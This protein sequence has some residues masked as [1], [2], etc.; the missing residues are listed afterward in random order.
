MRL[1]GLWQNPDFMRLWVGQ[2]VSVFGSMIGNLAL[3]FVAII[4]LNATPFQVATLG[5]MNLIPGFMAGLFAGVWVDRLP[6]K[7]VLIASDIGRFAVLLSVPAAALLGV[8]SL[9]QLYIVA[10]LNGVF[11]TFFDVAYHA[12]LPSLVRK[13]ELIEGNSK[14]SASASVAEAGG[15][16][17]AG[18][19]VQWLTAP[20]AIL[21]DALS[22]LFSALS[23]ARIQRAEP[24]RE[25]P[26]EQSNAWLEAKEGLSAL[27]NQPIVRT[28]VGSSTLLALF[29][30]IF[31]SMFLVFTTRELGLA[32]GVQGMIFAIGG[33]TSLLGAL[34]AGPLT[35]RFGLGPTLVISML[36][37]SLGSFAPTL[38]IG[39]G[40]AAI[41]LLILN[42]LLTD[43]AW[44]LH[45]INELTLRQSL[46]ANQVLGRVN[47]GVRF[48]EF[49]ANLLGMLVGGLLGEL[50]GARATLMIGAAGGLASALWLLASP[51]WRYRNLPPEEGRVI[52]AG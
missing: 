32:P 8:L 45:N 5:I 44:T 14:L 37:I 23:I 33:V 39:A 51:V 35:R 26:Q 3:P 15:F 18:W 42:Q 46:V 9:P 40:V 13:D 36:L 30:R 50:L 48:L 21:V 47:G 16:G 7:P 41:T 22:F 28:L 2:T 29:S 27:W 1:T 6:R 38:A 49:G 10:F 52:E 24:P 17:L 43:P 12:Y 20:I 4:S 19:L 25:Q 31:G 34:A 11:G